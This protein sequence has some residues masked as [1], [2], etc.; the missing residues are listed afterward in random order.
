VN[1]PRWIHNWQEKV[2]AASAFAQDPFC[3]RRLPPGGPAIGRAG[4]FP[5][6]H[7]RGRISAARKSYR[8]RVPSDVAQAREHVTLASNTSVPQPEQH[9]SPNDWPDVLVPRPRVM[10]MSTVDREL[11][12][13]AAVECVHLAR[14]T[15]DPEKKQVLLARAQEWLKLA[16]SNHAAE[17]DRLLASF[18]DKQMDIS[19]SPAQ[20][21]PAQQQPVQQQ[22]AKLEPKD[23]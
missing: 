9:Q 5:R 4:L 6:E 16:Y 11:C 2:L 17:F 14:V 20:G 1:V 12:R 19:K 15:S 10:R 18:N 22:Q 8:P 13:K 7:H 3:A 23:D 21:G